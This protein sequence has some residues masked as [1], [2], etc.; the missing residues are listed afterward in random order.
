M[1]Y[2]A[3]NALNQFMKILS[4]LC[5]IFSVGLGVGYY[6][7]FKA[8]CQPRPDGTYGEL[9]GPLT[10]Y[11]PYVIAASLICLL[12]AVVLWIAASKSGARPAPTK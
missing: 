2:G 1:R 4:T 3:R 7:A 6:F 8:Y 10:F 9:Y 11:K 5:F 12:I